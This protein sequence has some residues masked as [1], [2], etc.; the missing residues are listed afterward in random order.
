[1]SARLVLSPLPM[2]T[3]TRAAAVAS[4]RCS[5]AARLKRVDHNT[6]NFASL[7]DSMKD[8]STQVLFSPTL[9]VAKSLSHQIKPS[10]PQSAS[11]PWPVDG[12]AKA[13]E[14]DRKIDKLS[15]TFVHG[16]K[17]DRIVSAWEPAEKEFWL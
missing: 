4:I 3:V 16:E 13:F 8:S 12:F 15:K 11:L 2:R 7:N 10:T 9:A 5:E 6:T 1:M 17:Q 14:E